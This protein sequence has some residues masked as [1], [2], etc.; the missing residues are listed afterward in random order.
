M[1]QNPLSRTE[2][3]PPYSSK[4][5]LVFL[6]HA[7]KVGANNIDAIDKGISLTE[8]G[9]GQSI[10]KG[11]KL[12]LKQALA[13]ASNRDRTQET[14][15]YVL[16]GKD[17]QI[18]GD[19]SFDELKEKVDEGMKHGSR[20]LIDSRLDMPFVK[21]SPEHLELQE[22]ADNGVYF[23]TLVNKHDEILDQKGFDD[24]SVYAVQTKNI[25]GVIEKYVKMASVWDRL[26]KEKEKDYT[27][28]LERV[29]STHGAISESFLAEFIEKTQGKKERNA[30]VALF[31]NCFDFAEGFEVNIETVPDEGVIIRLKVSVPMEKGGTYE[32]DEVVSKEILESILNNQP[33]RG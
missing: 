16:A 10:E 8:H 30:F 32:L 18:T 20:L 23:E 3:I 26:V 28:T 1:E 6:R 5:H 11:K 33:K 4:V 7:E 14:A 22:A 27:D 19:E 12:D 31:P 21:G 2:S 13:V 25:A 17:E 9:R 15:M 29:L 24:E